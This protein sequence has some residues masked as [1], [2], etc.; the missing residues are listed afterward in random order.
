MKELKDFELESV[1]AGFLPP[2]IWEYLKDKE[3][4]NKKETNQYPNIKPPQIPENY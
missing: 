2:D 3:P 4:D 1:A